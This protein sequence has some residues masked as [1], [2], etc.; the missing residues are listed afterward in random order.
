MKKILFIMHRASLGGPG[1][2]LIF[3]L[4]E[5][6]KIYRVNVIVPEDGPLID[7]LKKIDVN[8]EIF[9]PRMR[10]IIKMIWII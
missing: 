5:L 2:S 10:Y 8:V 1:Q 7:E 3:N 6:K 4:L 9:F